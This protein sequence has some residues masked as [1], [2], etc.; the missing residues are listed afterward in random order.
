MAT[1]RGHQRDLRKGRFSEPG[2]LYHVIS[3][4]RERAPL[5]A[6]LASGRAVVHCLMHLEDAEACHTLAYVVM[7]DHIHWLLELR[8]FMTLPRLVQN[9]KINSARLVNQVRGASE[10][11]VWQSGYFD[12]ALRHEDDVRQIARYIVANPLRAGLVGSIREYPLWDA[13]W[14]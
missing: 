4:T 12:H 10:V 14:V 8:Q 13:V 9:F 5:F 6:E 3:A 7:P 2:R 1:R 11:P